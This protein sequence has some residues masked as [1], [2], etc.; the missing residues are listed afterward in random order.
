MAC[1]GPTSASR[2]TAAEAHLR[3]ADVR[4]LEVAWGDPAAVDNEH[5]PAA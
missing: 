4:G 5:G 2:V 1:P 3:A